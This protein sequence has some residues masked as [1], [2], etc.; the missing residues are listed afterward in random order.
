MEPFHKSA[1]FY[2]GVRFIQNG[3]K[4]LCLIGQ[5]GSG[6]TSTAKHLYMS[7]T[8]THPTVIRNPLIFDVGDKPVI[9]DNAIS[10]KITDDEKDQL[11]D[12]V[13]QLY[14]NMS[15]S[16]T[17]PFIIITL[18]EEMEHLYGFVKSLTPRPYD[19]KFINLSKSLTKGDRS[20]ILRSQFYFLNPNEDF[21]Q[22]KYLA[23]YGKDNSL[24][25]PE[26]CALFS[27]CSVFHN[28]GPLVFCNRPLQNLKRYLEKMH[29]SKNNKKF[30]VLVYMS[31]NQM[32]INVNAP[33]EMLFEILGSCNCSTSCRDSHEYVL[34]TL[35][36]EEFVIKET[37]T[38]NYKL[39]HEVIK[40]MTLIVFGTHHFDKL[41]E[42]SNPEDLKGWIK[43]KKNLCHPCERFRDMRPVLKI[44][45]EQWR[46]YQEN[47]SSNS[48]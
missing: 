16:G 36:S 26:I 3:G 47:L 32:E 46:K 34:T 23:L 44:K 11:G 45:R 2:E 27:R 24:G 18:D 6:K 8:D 28:V 19:V 38:L 21:S 40:R 7:V 4:L 31:L 41:L 30:L 10:K 13:R 9:L 25:Y 33:N 1:A 48:R 43:Q 15:R 20:Q 14:E 42:L 12:K 39:Q 5:W 17:K 22:V 35:L 37:N 29:H